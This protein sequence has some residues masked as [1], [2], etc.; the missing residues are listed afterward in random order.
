MTVA[1]QLAE[2]N[3]NWLKGPCNNSVNNVCVLQLKMSKECTWAL[4][5]KI[6]VMRNFLW[7]CPVCVELLSTGIWAC[8][9]WENL[10][11]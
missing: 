10:Q 7:H 4:V 5:F 9:S 8:M 3:K 6:R 2:I 1:K 11:L